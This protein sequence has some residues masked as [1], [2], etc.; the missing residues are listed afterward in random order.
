MIHAPQIADLINAKRADSYDGAFERL[1]REPWYCPHCKASKTI[2]NVMLPFGHTEEA[3][4]HEPMCGDCEKEG[5][6]L[7]GGDYIKQFKKLLNMLA[8]YNRSG[9]A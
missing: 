1:L 4:S 8:P 7:I 9:T 5:I 3:K 2:L 6:M